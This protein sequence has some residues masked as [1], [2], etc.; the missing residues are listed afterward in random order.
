MM[1]KDNKGSFEYKQLLEDLPR[2][3]LFSPAT[4]VTFNSLDAE[5]QTFKHRIRVNLQ[6]IIKAN[7]F[8]PEGDGNIKLPDQ[9]PF[10]GWFG[11]RWRAVL[12]NQ[13]NR[14]AGA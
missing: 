2:D 5:D 4:I 10:P 9:A 6:R 12:K 7:G 1:K 11:E 3:T 13:A 8:P 14:G